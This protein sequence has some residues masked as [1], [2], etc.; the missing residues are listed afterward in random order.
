MTDPDTKALEAPAWR[1]ISSVKNAK[2]TVQKNYP[3]QMEHWTGYKIERLYSEAEASTLRQERDEARLNA[4]Q[5]KANFGAMAKARTAHIDRAGRLTAL[6][7]EAG[8]VL[9]KTQTALEHASFALDGVVS[10]DD[11][12]EGKDGGSDTCQH[13]KT[14]VDNAL[15]KVVALSAK[16]KDATDAR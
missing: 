8:K 6:L 14:T 13:A 4:A 7:A 5:W 2:W 11:E 15:K 1:Y 10:T 3:A 16:I 12:D 9:D